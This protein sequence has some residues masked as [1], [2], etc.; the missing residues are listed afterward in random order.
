MNYNEAVILVR[1]DYGSQADDIIKS[2]C[3]EAI[4]TL[5]QLNKQNVKRQINNFTLARLSAMEP[6]KQA[7]YLANPLL[8]FMLERCISDIQNPPTV[9]VPEHNVN[10]TNNKNKNKNKNVTPVEPKPE[11]KPTPKP[12]PEPDPDDDPLDTPFDLFG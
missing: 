5:G 2:L 3:E 7:G 12:D 6:H 10:V 4:I 1:N 8:Q 9:S 11:P